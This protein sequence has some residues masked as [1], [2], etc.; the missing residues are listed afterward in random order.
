[1]FSGFLPLILTG[2]LWTVAVSVAALGVG[3]LLGI[4]LA[5]GELSRSL[6]IRLPTV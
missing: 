1:M 4:L 2:L 5:L 6:F 3:L